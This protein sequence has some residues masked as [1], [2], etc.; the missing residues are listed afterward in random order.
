MVWSYGKWINIQFLGRYELIMYFMYCEFKILCI[1]TNV[2]LQLNTCTCA[3]SV[4]LSVVKTEFFHFYT[5]LHAFTP[6][7]MHLH[8]FTCIYI[9]LH[10]STS[11]FVY[12]CLHASTCVYM[13]LHVFICIYMHLRVLTGS[14]TTLVRK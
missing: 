6:L 13:C 12:M 1:Y 14:F 11:T 9:C 5:P 8:A 3:L 2:F 4:C 7:Y 10:A